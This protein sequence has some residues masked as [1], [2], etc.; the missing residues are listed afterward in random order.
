MAEQFSIRINSNGLGAAV[1]FENATY[2]TAYF[3]FAIEAA[4]GAVGST[5]HRTVIRRTMEWFGAT[6][7]VDDDPTSG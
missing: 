1:R 6:S 3:G 2:K 4:C 5:H 7:D